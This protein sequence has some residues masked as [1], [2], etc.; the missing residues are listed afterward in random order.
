MR[1]LA[2]ENFP[3]AEP[4]TG[5]QHTHDA[6]KYRQHRQQRLHHLGQSLRVELG[7]S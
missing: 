5:Y 7:T 4:E 2:N 3:G 6:R 1:F